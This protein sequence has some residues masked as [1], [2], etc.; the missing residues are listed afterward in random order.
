MKLEEM[1]ASENPKLRMEAVRQ[2]DNEDILFDIAQND[3]NFK[4]CLTAVSKS[5]MNRSYLKLQ[6]TINSV[7]FDSMQFEKSQMM[8]FLLT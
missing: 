7:S 2:L 6:K 8:Q 3:S 5:A 4:V 1:L